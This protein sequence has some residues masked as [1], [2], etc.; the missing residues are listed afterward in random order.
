MAQG[1]VDAGSSLVSQNPAGWLRK[2]IEEDYAPPRNPKR[3]RRRQAREVQ[4]TVITIHS[5]QT[6]ATEKVERA[7]KEP[8]LYRENNTGS[9][10]LEKTDRENQ[11]T[12]QK[13]LEQLKG[14]LPTGEVEA[15]LQGTILLQVTD[16][17]AQIGVPNRFSLAWLERRMYLEITKAMKSVL[18]KDLDLQFVAAS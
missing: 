8:T 11:E 15:R 4:D 18:G 14:T 12:W 17:I 16:T 3:S 9:K 6:V 5:I 13:A 1:L 10:E 2:A 7:Q